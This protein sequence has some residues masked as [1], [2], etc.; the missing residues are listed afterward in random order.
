MAMPAAGLPAGLSRGYLYAV[1][2][3]PYVVPGDGTLRRNPACG[4]PLRGFEDRC[5]GSA[6]RDS[7]R[8]AERYHGGHFDDFYPA[9]SGC[10]EQRLR[11]PAIGILSNEYDPRLTAANRLRRLV[12]AD[13]V[14]RRRFQ[15]LH[16]HD[17]STRVIILAPGKG[18]NGLNARRTAAEVGIAIGTFHHAI[19]L[20]AGPSGPFET[21]NALVD[22]GATYTTVPAVILRLAADP[23]NRRLVPLPEL[24]LL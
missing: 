24:Y 9:F 12:R 17:H 7:A 22:A 10:P 2:Y 21:I 19:E 13:R 3:A 18:V 15:T 8:S 23:V 11:H 16:V 6:D 20:G 5:G 1:S 14:L 4:G